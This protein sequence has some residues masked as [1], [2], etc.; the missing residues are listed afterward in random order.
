[1]RWLNG[2]SPRL[3]APGLYK[4][5]RY[6]K[7]S[8]STELHN[9]NWIKNF[10]N[11]QCPTL[12]EEFVQLYL[13]VSTVTLSDPKDVITWKWTASGRFSVASN[14]DCQFT[15]AMSYFP[16]SEIWKATTKPNCIFFAWLIMHNKTPTADNLA[17]KNWDHNPTCSLCYCLP[18]TV[19]HLLTECNYTEALWNS[20]CTVYNLSSF[21]TM[22]S[23]GGP[24]HW[25]K[26]TACFRL[27]KREE[28]KTWYSFYLLV[29]NLEG[30]E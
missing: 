30:E 23:E 2:S 24:L 21:S 6:K 26:E 22:V 12:L 14:Y 25:G 11:I 13:A 3:L 29:A 28:G 5:A 7:K 10:G 9:E 17:K 27:H 4:Q 15:C 8:V 20:I 1:V 16:A 19:Q 18:E